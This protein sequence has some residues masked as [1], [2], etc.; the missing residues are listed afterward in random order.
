M[1]AA[2]CYWTLQQWIRIRYTLAP[3][4][5]KPVKSLYLKEIQYTNTL[6]LQDASIH[7]VPYLSN[8]TI[9][10]DE[11]KMDV[12]TNRRRPASVQPSSSLQDRKSVV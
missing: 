2:V 1:W 11:A 4:L 10:L 5:L 6:T 9:L 8:T 12:E 3:C 7:M